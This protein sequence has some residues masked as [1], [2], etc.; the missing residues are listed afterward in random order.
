[1]TSPEV[2]C[3]VF[4]EHGIKLFAETVDIE[5]L[6]GVFRAFVDQA[7]EIAEADLHRLDKSHIHEKLRL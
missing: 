6:E 4:K 7:C 3:V 1:M 5:I 2:F